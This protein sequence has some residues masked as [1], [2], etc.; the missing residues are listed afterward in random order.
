MSVG[1][2]ASENN[3][4]SGNATGGAMMASVSV[5][6]A[7]VSASTSAASAL[8]IDECASAEASANENAV[9]VMNFCWPRVGGDYNLNTMRNW[10]SDGV[11]IGRCDDLDLSRCCGDY[12]KP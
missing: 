9:M 10:M 6:A 8:A 4:E 3:D 2:S 7:T 1:A 12:S 11:T 5:R